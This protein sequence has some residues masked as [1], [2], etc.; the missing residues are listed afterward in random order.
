MNK[1][2]SDTQ[3]SPLSSLLPSAQLTSSPARRLVVLI[4][5]AESINTDLTRRIWELASPSGLRVLFL[6]LCSDGSEEP[7]LRR[8]LVTLAAAIQDTK[9][10]TEIRIEFGNDWIEKVKTVWRPGDAL[11]CFAEQQAGLRHRP[12]SQV[13]NSTFEAPVYILSGLHPPP[14][15]S[16][17]GFLSQLVSWAGSIGIILGFFWIQVKIDQLPKDWAH[18]TLLCLSVL[19]EI[20][21]IWLW[22]SLTA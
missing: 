1:P 16:R 21:L 4:P 3:N 2:D 5:D 8:Q 18:T 11:V 15:G 10:S 13:L 12:L 19:V 20:G 7:N 22:N 9:V 14:R 17:S 6:S